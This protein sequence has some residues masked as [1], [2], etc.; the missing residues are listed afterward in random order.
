MRLWEKDRLIRFISFTLIEL[1]VTVAI[2][3][4]LASLLL[5]SLQK[6]RGSAEKITCSSQMR[7]LGLV[8]SGYSSD[9]NTSC[10][11]PPQTWD[12]VLIN[13]NYIKPE[14]TMC[15]T[16]R[17]KQEAAG[18]IY[19]TGQYAIDADIK[20][21]GPS[22]SALG[23]IKSPGKAIF[24]CDA[25]GHWTDLGWNIRPL[26]KFEDEIIQWH[27]GYGNVSFMDGHVEA[28]KKENVIVREYWD[29]RLWR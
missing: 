23:Q 29:Y 7:Q 17:K 14:M 12:W 25:K 1:L 3:A 18:E 27:M 6:A 22:A 26:D 10:I 16:G 5:P 15:P 9:Y 28:M 19:Y 20:L 2:M 4:I 8:F 24:M 13:N 11:M 21:M